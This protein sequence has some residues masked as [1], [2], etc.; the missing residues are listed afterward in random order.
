MRKR[1]DL[2]LLLLQSFVFL[3]SVFTIVFFLNNIPQY[4]EILR[5]E[6]VLDTC[7]SLA[8]APPTTLEKLAAYHLTPETYS[9]WFVIIESTFAFLFYFAA[10]IIF[11]KNKRGGMGF[12]AVIALVAYGTT[13]TSLIYMGSEG[14]VLEWAPEVIAGIG[15]I[16]LFLFLLLFPNGRLVPRWTLFV[17]VPFCVIQILSLMMPG[18]KFDLLN[19][20]NMA[21]LIY[22]LLMI[23]VTIF[24]QI[25]RYRKVSGS[26]EQ[27]QTKW[28][29]YGVAIS[30][31]GSIILS[32]FFVY[33]I[34][35]ENPVSYIYLSASLY[36]VVAIIPLTLVLAILR[37]R[38]WDIDPL[39]NRTILYGA[40]SLS[41]ILLYSGLVMYLSSLFKT[42]GSFIISLISTA[43]VAVLFSPLKER[44]QRIVNRLMKGRHDDPYAVL[45]ELGDHLSKPLA[46]EEVLQVV[47]EIVKDALRLPFVGISI[48][49]N[50]E[51]KMA[52]SSGAAVFDVHYF[53]IVHGGEE[54]GILNV[55]SRSAEEVFTAEDLRLMDVMLRQAG[56][57]VQTVKMT[58]GMQVLAT[59]LQASRERLVFAREEE[60]LQIRRN[61]HDDLA[62]K[63]L[64]LS[65]NVA[66]AEQY[67]KKN[68]DKTL[69]LLGDLR[70]VIRTTVSEIRTMVH[71]LRPPT[72]DEFGLIGSIQARIDEMKKSS[73]PLMVSFS[74]PVQMPLLP[75]A[76]EVAA[77]RII[78][79]ALV[80]V[81]KHA[82]AAQC[83]VLISV[84]SER[85][86][87]IEVIDDGIGLPNHIKPS[88]SGGLGLKS[89]RERTSEL[90][91]YCFIGKINTG[92]TRVKALLPFLQG[93]EL[94]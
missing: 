11:L 78:T 19:W 15:R 79:E 60:R 50:G 32:G 82:K 69:E 61:L 74:A 93:E 52:A 75:A 21:R 62:P 73:V 43:V 9:L 35:A 14:G 80:N 67:V 84:I 2:K 46:P 7:S 81:V 94:T 24:S 91:G 37:H 86:L 68:P 42:E 8:P 63:L 88:C 83:S 3:F 27:Q 56:P 12:L 64:S 16:S 70:N 85:D 18:T 49:V 44:L 34:Y 65:F 48:K 28:V 90:G 22:Y 23:A 13:F 92:G 53:P 33:P 40:L 89:I 26:V 5:L 31:I 77:Y 25:F 55:S 51:E 30:F 1:K 20:S 41:I 36:A 45:K 4:F 29:V 47:S 54:L 87:E 10:S 59:D 71:D 17:F 66:A 57:I 72:L 58:W 6:C 38:L 39:V 76:V